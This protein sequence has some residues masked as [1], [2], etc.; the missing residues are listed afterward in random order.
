MA[1]ADLYA[2]CRILLAALPGDDALARLAEHLRSLA[3]VEGVLALWGRR[4]V[5]TPAQ[6]AGALLGL[7][8]EGLRDGAPRRQAGAVALP[9]RAEGRA[10]GVLAVAASSA[11][12]AAQAEFLER[13]AALLE[14]ALAAQAALEA[15]RN[16]LRRDLY[17]LQKR[18]G[19][20][21]AL[22]QV[23]AVS[24][25]MQDALEQVQH[26]AGGRA[27]LLFCG[28]A[29]TGKEL[30]ARLTHGLG[31]RKDGPFVAVDCG[32]RPE[33]TLVRRLFV[34]GF[35][36]AGGGT[37]F[38]QDVTALPAAL[39]ERL[40]RM[41]QEAEPG[42]RGA[43]QEARLLFAA[44]DPDDEAMAAD[45]LPAEI[46]ARFGGV[47]IRLPPLRARAEDIPLLVDLI[48]QGFNAEHQCRVRMAPPAL[49]ALLSRPF[50]GNVPEL[51][52]CVR[53]LAAAAGGELVRLEDV[54][55]EGAAI[56]IR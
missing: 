35:D 52:R 8:E 18:A 12:L 45:P 27:P 48:L 28:E 5:A 39:R 29:G 34:D 11:W 14:Q 19:D 17:S 40:L 23:V 22:P 46:I 50:P 42:G 4:R 3:E 16:A 32:E 7:A 51:K 38:L 36:R 21:S 15:E 13:T 54:Q 43:R 6:T 30:L 26:H 31:P 56:D 10:R 47:A 49:D 20:W 37:L 25:A 24:R 53:R 1:E 2:V 9:L 55:R 33:P 44:A 41:M